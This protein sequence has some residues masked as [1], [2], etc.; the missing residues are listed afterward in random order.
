[1]LTHNNYSHRTNL[2]NI[3]A[4]SIVFMVLVS[5]DIFQ[6]AIYGIFCQR[7]QQR[8]F[9]QLHAIAHIIL[10]TKGP[11]VS[12]LG[13]EQLCQQYLSSAAVAENQHPGIFIFPSQQQYIQR[14]TFFSTT[15]ELTRNIFKITLLLLTK[16]ENVTVKGW[17]DDK[18]LNCQQGGVKIE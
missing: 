7:R 9:A 12:H 2:K 16:K 4:L 1:M 15:S 14:T 11:N 13:P 10:M 18:S 8:R 17:H 5:R 3:I 6:I